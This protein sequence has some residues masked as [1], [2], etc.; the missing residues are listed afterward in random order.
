MGI[1]IARQVSLT[2]TGHP[3]DALVPQSLSNLLAEQAIF[4]LE[5]GR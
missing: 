1:R 4:L 2:K 3:L 5:R